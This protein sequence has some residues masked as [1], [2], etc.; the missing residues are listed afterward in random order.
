MHRQVLELRTKVFGKGHPD[1]ISRMSNLALVV[2]SQG[3][4][5]EAEKMALTDAGVDGENSGKKVS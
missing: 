5:D 1:T 4:Y 3:E 2:R